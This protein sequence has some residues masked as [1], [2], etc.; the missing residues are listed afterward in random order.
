MPYSSNVVQNN[1]PRQKLVDEGANNVNNANANIGGEEDEFD[2]EE[3]FD[4]GDEVD[5]SSDIPIPIL[6]SFLVK[7]NLFINLSNLIEE[8]V[9]SGTLESRAG[10]IVAL[11]YNDRIKGPSHFF[12]T[13]AGFKNACHVIMCH[14][15]VKRKKKLIHIKVTTI[16]F[17]VVGVPPVDVEKVV[18]KL[19]SI[20]EKHNKN[21]RIFKTINKTETNRLEI[22]IVPILNNYTMNLSIKKRNK[23]F[24]NSKVDIIQKFIDEK[25]LS[26]MVPGDKAITIKK[27]FTYE[28]FSNHPVK[29]IVWRKKHGKVVKYTDYESYTTLLYGRQKDNAFR[30]KYITLRLFCTG[31]VCISGFSDIMVEEV[32]KEFLK[33]CDKF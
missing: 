28:N 16:G 19:F 27:S 30:K 9:P 11:K 33:I 23:I 31:T 2:L 6:Q 4:I 17:Q 5:G 21:E 32:V 1:P 29:Y 20:L 3:E 12:K 13:K 26:F 25:F 10:T 7:T 24:K 8:L 18:Y 15:F 14:T 22:L